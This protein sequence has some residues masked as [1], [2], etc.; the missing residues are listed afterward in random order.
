MALEDVYSYFENYDKSTYLAVSCKGKEPSEED[1]ASFETLVGFRMPNEFREFTLSSL[2][3]LCF[4]VREELWRRSRSCDFGPFWTVLYGIK[5]FGIARDIPEWLDIRVQQQTFGGGL[6]PFLQLVGDADFYCFDSVGRIVSWCSEAPEETMFVEL[7][8]SELLM[9]EIG[10]LEI[11]KYC[12]MH[13]LGLL[14]YKRAAKA[15]KGEVHLSSRVDVYLER[16]PDSLST[17]LKIKKVFGLETSI[18]ELKKAMDH[19]PSPIATNLTYFQ[20]IRR[21]VEFGLDEKYLGIRLTG[22][23]ALILPIDEHILPILPIDGNVI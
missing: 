12:K 6:V 15:A 18:G 20:A 11:R 9:R 5:V 8:F 10:E 21:C 22:E 7:T 3:G 16:K 23:F 13:N 17:L 1:L 2:G 14:D 19:T 4:E